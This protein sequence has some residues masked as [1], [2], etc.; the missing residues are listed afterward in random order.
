M[1]LILYFVIIISISFYSFAEKFVVSD[2]LIKTN[3]F[4]IG[5]L[6]FILNNDWQ[7]N[8]WMLINQF[9]QENAMRCNN[10]ND[11]VELSL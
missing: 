8:K 4:P 10:R 9:Q 1:F 7:R 5:G 6:I 2:W 11:L 3:S